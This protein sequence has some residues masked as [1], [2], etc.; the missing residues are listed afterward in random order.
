MLCRRLFNGPAAQA[1][2]ALQRVNNIG[3]E[4]F[5]IK[6]GIEAIGL[7]A[8]FVLFKDSRVMLRVY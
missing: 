5:P 3:H 2:V 7:L 8:P 6:L 4:R 1:E